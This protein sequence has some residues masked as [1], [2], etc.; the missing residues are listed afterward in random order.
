MEKF[1]GWDPHPTR[2]IIYEDL[3]TGLLYR[4]RESGS[5]DMVPLKMTEHQVLEIFR[6]ADGVVA[7]TSR[8]R[9]RVPPPSDKNLAKESE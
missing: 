2:K 3:K 1:E 6:K 4:R 7:M 8:S 5:F 9:G